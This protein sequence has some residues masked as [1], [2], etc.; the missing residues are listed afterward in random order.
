MREKTGQVW[1][2]MLVKANRV[3]R[4]A[5]IEL[6]S[7]LGKKREVVTRQNKIDPML[8]EY[9]DTLNEILSRAH[10]KAEAAHY[11]QF[12]VQLQNLRQRGSEDIQVIEQ[13]CK[14]ARQKALS[15]DQEK[16]KLQKLSQRSQAKITQRRKVKEVKDIDAQNLIQFNLNSPSQ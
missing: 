11:R 2:L 12:I 3:L 15:A 7:A 1:E 14:E 8:V 13:F 6:D 5:Q 9:S 4:Q 10:N 16:L